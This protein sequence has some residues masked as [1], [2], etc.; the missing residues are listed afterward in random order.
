MNS[1]RSPLT[2]RPARWGGGV[3]KIDLDRADAIIDGVRDPSA[4][5]QLPAC[6]AGSLDLFHYPLDT[7][8]EHLLVA[9]VVPHRG[10]V[11]QGGVKNPSLS[12][13]PRPGEWPTVIIKWNRGELI[14]QLNSLFLEPV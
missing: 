14:E 12:K 4:D 3:F 9:R 13:T 7:V 10:F 1:L 2:P 6:I 8:Q 11:A 5:G